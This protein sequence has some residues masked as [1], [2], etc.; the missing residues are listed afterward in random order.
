MQTDTATL[1]HKL[2]SIAEL[3]DEDRQALCAMP[4]QVRNLQS[5]EDAIREGDVPRACCLLIE[6][7]LHRYKVL[8]DGKR[9]ILAFHTPGDIPDLQ[10]LCLK[11]MDHSLAALV[12]C[13]VGF[14]AHDSL[15]AVMRNSP[16]IADALWRDTLIDAAIFRA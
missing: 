12:P 5:G 7:F 4:L 15:R 11:V 8:P 9:Q 14:I 10:S 6:G 3:T 1:L 13:K 16:G 2:D